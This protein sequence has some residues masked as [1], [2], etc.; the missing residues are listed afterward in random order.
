MSRKI[1]ILSLIIFS[2]A[3]SCSEEIKPIPFDYSRILSGNTSKTWVL[4]RW[5]LLRERD[6]QVDFTFN[7]YSDLNPC[8]RDDRYIFYRNPEK[9]YEVNNGFLKC[10]ANEP[11]VLLSDT[12]SFTNA[13]ATFYFVLPLIADFAVPFIVKEID[14]KNLTLM[15]YL[16]QAG[17]VKWEFGFE[18]ISE[19]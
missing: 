5:V 9:A 11:D 3:L 17:T 14:N 8:M 15:V 13:G 19:N 16:D 12:W 1:T 18:S 2:L 10:S 6:G 4:R 7:E